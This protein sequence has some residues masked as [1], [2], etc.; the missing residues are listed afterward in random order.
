MD[1]YRIVTVSAF[2][3]ESVTKK[4]LKALGVVDPKAEEGSISFSGSSLDVARLNMF[5]RTADRVYIEVGRFTA[6]TFDALFDGIS[7][8]PWENHLDAD[9]AFVVTGKSKKSALFAVSS[10]QSIIKKAIINRLSK[11]TN[12][13]VFPET[14]AVFNIEFSINADVVTVLLNTSGKGL[15]K[16]GYRDLV[17]EAPMRETLAGALL[18][19]SDF[20]PENAFIDPFCG[21]GTIVIEAARMAL[22]IASG[23]DREFDFQKW[24]KFDQSVYD[25]ARQ[26]ALDNEKRD[27]PL[28]VSGFDIDPEAIKLATRHAVRAGVKDKIHLQVRDVAE[29]KSRFAQGTIVTNPPYGERLMDI[30][31]V[32]QLYKT[33]GEV[34]RALDNWSIFVITSAPEFERYFGLRSDKNRKLFNAGK[35]CRF[36]SYF[37]RL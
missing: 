3:I 20:N 5:L 25:I 17:G 6:A 24:S 18:M 15:H 29:L 30:K 32:N 16:R 10:C 2:G 34:Y 7:E 4:E 26:E 31:T 23:I 8:I 27:A 9:G 11:H 35:E 28:R 33:L 22:D 21:S 13:K 19:L 1:T 12:F 14:G 37:R 36:Y